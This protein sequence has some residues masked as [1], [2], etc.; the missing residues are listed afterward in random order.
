LQAGAG[1][2]TFEP[3]FRRLYPPLLRF[4]VNRSVLREE[5]DDLAQTTLFRAFQ[6]IGQYRF[7]ASFRAWVRRIGE[8]VWKNAVRDRQAAKRAS[9]PEVLDMIAVDDQKASVLPGTGLG[10]VPATP[11]ELA[12]TEEKAEILREAIEKLPPG[13]RRCIEL[14]LFAGL[15]YREIADLMGIGLNTV[16]SQLSEARKRLQPVLDEHFP[17]ADF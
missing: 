7:E 12:L 13:M 14:R 17:G 4:F 5:A 10:D 8:N 16:R 2:E 3:I 6:S 1:S 9:S 11:E 15:K